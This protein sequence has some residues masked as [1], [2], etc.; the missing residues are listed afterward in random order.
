MK[1]YS[2]ISSNIE[3]V[4]SSSFNVVS[5]KNSTSSIIPKE[6]VIYLFYKEEST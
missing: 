1:W 2:S 4:R 5:S 3:V 6:V